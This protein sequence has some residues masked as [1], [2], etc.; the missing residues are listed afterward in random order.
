M[1]GDLS[2]LDQTTADLLAIMA[3]KEEEWGRQGR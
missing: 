2:N 1:S 3:D